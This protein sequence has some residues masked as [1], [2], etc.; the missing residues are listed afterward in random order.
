MA[1]EYKIYNLILRYVAENHPD[2]EGN[3]RDALIR[4]YCQVFQ[5]I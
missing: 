3:E 5:S 1:D 4:R 2:A